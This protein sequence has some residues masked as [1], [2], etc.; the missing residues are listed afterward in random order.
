[1][2]RDLRQQF[3]R[4]LTLPLSVCCFQNEIEE[5]KKEQERT[6]EEKDRQEEYFLE[7]VIKV[8]GSSARFARSDGSMDLSAARGVN[9]G[10]R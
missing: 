2:W 4:R 5:L 10:E 1:M 7:Q 3:W 9:R 6:R 8:L